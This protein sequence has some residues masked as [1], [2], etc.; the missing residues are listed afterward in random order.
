MNW[1]IRELDT[2]LEQCLADHRLSP[3][4]STA[5]N[6]VLQEVRSDP[7]KLARIRNYAFEL[8]ARERSLS[9][10]GIDESAFTWLQQVITLA[11][12]SQLSELK[13][14][15]QEE[16]EVR[17][18]FSPGNDCRNAILRNIGQAHETL[19]ICVFTISDDEISSEVIAAHR[20]GCAIRIITDDDKSHDLGSDADAFERAGIEVRYDRSQAHMHHKFAVFDRRILLTGSFNWTRSAT[21]LNQENVLQTNHGAAINSYLDTFDKLWSCYR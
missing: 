1:P 12:R 11:Q 18:W 10:G 20:R 2:A 21:Q 7:S 4:E 9:A 6:A 13:A 17:A 19:D 5:L 8:V 14:I 15:Q 16:V 3:G